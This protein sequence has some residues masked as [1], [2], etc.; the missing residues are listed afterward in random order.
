MDRGGT[1][2]D[3][4]GRRPDGGVTATKLLSDNPDHYADAAVEGIRRLMGLA[5]GEAVP[6]E[7]I[8]VVRMGTT[9]ATN[10]LLERKGEP[11]AL[12]VTRGFGDALR[13]A[14]QNRPRLFDREI[15]LPERLYRTVI[16][17]DERVAVDGAVVVPLD[18]AAAR[19]AMAAAH[20]DGLRAIAIVL[21][22]GYRHPAHEARLAAIAAEIGFTQISVS[23]Q[24]SPLIRFVA[25]GDTTV[26]D[27]YLSPVLRRYVDRV[28][29]SLPGVPLQFMQS[30]GGLTDA[31]A[32]QGKDSVLSGPAGGIVGMAGISRQAGHDRVI[33]FDMGGTS[34][35]V[36]HYAGEYERAFDTM[37]AGVRL[38]APMMSI[39]TVAAG[40]GSILHFDGA[41]L[42]AGPDSAGAH[43]G[44]ACYR[45]GGPLTV[46]DANVMLGR[47]QPEFFPSVFGTDGRQPLD[48][49]VVRQRFA[50]LAAE[51]TE[52]TGQAA[53]PEA[54]AQGFL[55]IAVANM[56][57]AIK[58][59]SVQR[60]YD[61]TQ[62][63]LTTFGG[64]GG[65]HACQ[66]A[67]ALAM[68][69]VLI[70]PLA[71]VLSAY[72]IGM[73]VSTA[74]RERSIEQRLDDDGIAEA[75]RTLDELTDAARAELLAQ[76]IDAASITVVRR[77][78]L[79]YEGTDTSLPVPF[80][81]RARMLGE[82]ERAYRQRFSFLMPQRALIIESA[83]VEANGGDAMAAG[84]ARPF[85]RRARNADA[86]GANGSVSGTDG[87]A[88]ADSAAAA[89]A[90]DGADG[91]DGAA[92]GPRAAARIRLHVAGEWID[93]PLYRV[94][95]LCADD[96]IDGPAVLSDAHA[97]TLVEPGWRA[98]ATADG[99]L[100]LERAV[101]RP[102]R[103]AIGTHADPVMLEIFNNLFM[104]I[105]EQMGYRLQNTAYSVNIKERLDFSCAIFDADGG[106]VANAPHMPVHL[107]SMGASIRAV[108][109]A[110]AGSLRPGDVYVLND[111][112]AGGTHL[113][114]I[115]VVT[116]VFDDAGRNVLFYVG[117][118]GHHADIGGLTP[119]S[120]PPDSTTIDDEGVL[121]TNFLLIRDG[122]FREQALRELLRSARH[123]ARN[124]EQN[125]ADLRAQVAA[126]E[127]GREELLKMVDDFGLDVVRA[128]MRHVQDNAEESVR[129]AI[130]R[131]KPGRFAL[132]LDNGAT[133]DVA[134]SIDARARDATL[135]FSASSPQ[136]PNNFNAPYAV[137]TAAV[138]YVFRTLVD[139]EIPMNAGCLKP[140]SVIVPP[141]S[142]MNPRHPAA[143]VAGN[144]ETSTCI[145][146]ALYGAM[147]VMASSQPTMNNLTF[148]NARHQYYETISG[149]SGAGGRFDDEGR[150]IGG[151]DGTSVVQTH[152]T[153]SRL[154]DPE[155]L[156][157]RYPVRLERYRIREG[158]G[159]AG[160][161]RGGDG[162]IRTIRFLEP[163]TVS[164][165]ANGWHHP[166]F[167]AAGG[168]AGAPGVARVLRADG[169]I[170][171]ID[172][173][174]RA[175]LQAGDC[176]EIE[177]P[178]GGGFGA[179]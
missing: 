89:D 73:A 69:R 14:Y 7:R 152:M 137:T 11:V 141:G 156:E 68:P 90:A 45:H 155:V 126:N 130:G 4:I 49:D 60:G 35:D 46:T 26:V 40:G 166:A 160:R 8:A 169:R 5:P 75:G 31:A 63:T 136:L 159:G 57:N 82:F 157:L 113:P 96:R 111:P 32:F 34:T 164:L 94:D 146:N 128:Y 29:A 135:D 144:V 84:D 33:G 122:E 100:V 25:R 172:H 44:P 17:I 22:H 97:T 38:R 167:G 61:I 158:S 81:D 37:V 123:P 153:N 114:D 74:M 98:C 116:P 92:A 36:S 179:R 131:L 48:V 147:G 138:L 56:A 53:T 109:D 77:L 6:A 121:I 120:M 51:V 83:V 165:L 79:R 148:G 10:A 9:V 42:R 91:A 124:P 170:E 168:Q 117:S 161:W 105:A 59:I 41:R 78:H 106:L 162:G 24:V 55:D 93:A 52:A 15:S 2:T 67:D 145:T 87:A 39:H 88:A 112:Y 118:R 85:A 175:E 62:Y 30:S 95:E 176:F 65:Q 154:T 19:A 3:V 125:L 134:L 13:I 86:D 50:A 151:F 142:M 99:N 127:K 66:V 133:I 101:P 64:A 150:L 143:V 149:G 104:S 129:R 71:G 178:G 107:G 171:S 173:A 43:P 163:M 28:S 21:M 139:D 132:T 1:F 76:R 80:A 102:Q 119:G 177:T 72:G 23:H 115:T 47:L 103:R 18:E 70:H 27:A 58:R 16:E 54:L 174:D 20:A 12:A 140:L 110:N 108:I